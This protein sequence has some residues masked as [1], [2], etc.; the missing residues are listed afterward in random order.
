LAEFICK[1][2]FKA[3]RCSGVLT[4]RVTCALEQEIF[5][6]PLS[7]KIAGWKNRYKNAEEA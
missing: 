4:Y 1:P 6:R 2:K 5:L 7:A 3:Q